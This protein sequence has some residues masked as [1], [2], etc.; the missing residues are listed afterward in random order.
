VLF[1]APTLDGLTEGWIDRTFRRWTVVRPKVGSRFTSRA[2]VVEVTSIEPLAEADLTE[3]DAYAAGFESREA[4]LR[5]TARKGSGDLYRIGIRLAGPDP[6]LALRGTDQ[7]DAAQIAAIT[8]RL[9]RMDRA[10]DRPWT[11]QVLEQIRRQPAVVST[12]LAAE[13]GE[14]RPAYK[15]R[16][17]RL[18]SLGLTE[19]L[20]VGY[21][22]SPR[23]V[24]YLRAV[25]P[26]ERSALGD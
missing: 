3:D 22:L 8:A 25:G 10:A 5:R 20:E 11:R 12:V 17:R 21:R 24:A 1:D 2:G 14:E 23:G 19:S 18:K 16:V 7:L 26:P 13:A 9:D 6:R 15:L 4:L